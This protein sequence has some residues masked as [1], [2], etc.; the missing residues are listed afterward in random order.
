[1]P[2]TDKKSIK[3]HTTN[4]ETYLTMQMLQENGTTKTG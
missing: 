2:A 3:M 1:M 4:T